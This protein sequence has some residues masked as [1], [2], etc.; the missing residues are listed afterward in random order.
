MDLFCDDD[1]RFFFYCW[2]L[3]MSDSM[4]V[5]SSMMSVIIV[6]VTTI[7]VSVNMA[8]YSSNLGTFSSLGRCC[9]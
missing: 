1:L 9:L 6:R 3:L 8:V 7:T 2:L 5:E 4:D